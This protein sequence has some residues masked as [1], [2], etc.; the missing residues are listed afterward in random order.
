MFVESMM[1]L[2][3]AGAMALV[4]AIA[5]DTWQAARTGFAGLF[6]RDGDSRRS[7]IAAQLDEDAATVARAGGTEVDQVRQELLPVWQRR[8]VQLLEQ[9]PEAEAELRELVTTVNEGLPA[10]RRG[11]VQTNI[12]R[13]NSTLFAVQDGQLHYHQAPPG[14]LPPTT[15]P[16]QDS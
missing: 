9:H 2:A 8:L 13:D 4:E 10:D 5:T 1:A 14:Q 6:G 3:G 12:A 16:H 7:A 11:W 15:G